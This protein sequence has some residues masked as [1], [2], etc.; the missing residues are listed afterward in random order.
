MGDNTA[1]IVGI[2]LLAAC[3]GLDFRA[4]LKTSDR[5]EDAKRT[6]RSKVP[7]YDRDRY[8]SPD[9]AAAKQLVESSTLNG[10]LP[11]G[12]LPSVG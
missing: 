12:L 8:F 3:Q 10:F 7:F 4:P 11:G 5:L 9:I 1:G 2:E 6:L